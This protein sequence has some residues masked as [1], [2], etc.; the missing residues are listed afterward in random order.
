M[1]RAAIVAAL[2]VGRDPAWSG[3]SGEGMVLGECEWM[4]QLDLRRRGQKKG[5]TESPRSTALQLFF[6]YL[7]IYLLLFIG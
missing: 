6:I 4:S 7:F 5:A 1:A 2:L 3:S